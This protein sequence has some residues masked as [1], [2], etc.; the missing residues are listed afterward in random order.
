MQPTLQERYQSKSDPTEA[1]ALGLMQLGKLHENGFT[2]QGVKVGIVDFGF[3]GY[4]R[5][6]Q[7]G[8]VPA[9]TQVRVF[10][11]EE[12]HSIENGDEH[13]AACAEIIHAAAPGAR[14]YLAMIDSSWSAWSDAAAWMKE[15]GVQIVSFSGGS[16]ASE[17]RGGDPLSRVVDKQVREDG[18][19]W[20]ISA[21]NH[22]DL[23]WLLSAQKAD[24]EGWLQFGAV[25]E[26]LFPSAPARWKS[27]PTSGVTAS[28]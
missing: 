17:L 26:V 14:L 2:G 5:L 19:L 22:G 8:L 4:A 25:G 27:R 10:G 20:V 3:Q 12:G 15:E 9:P 11:E 23:H 28:L 6:Q 21:G 13:G 24:S 1:D 18:R 16:V 7:K